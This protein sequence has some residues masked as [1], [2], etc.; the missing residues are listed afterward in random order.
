MSSLKLCQKRKNGVSIPHRYFKNVFAVQ[1]HGEYAESFQFL[2]GTL[3]MRE[4]IAA[5]AKRST[6]FQFLIGTLK[7]AFPTGEDY[8]MES[9][10]SS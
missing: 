10:N 1:R 2:I 3:K 6:E 5:D 8:D 9:F 7:I 4:G